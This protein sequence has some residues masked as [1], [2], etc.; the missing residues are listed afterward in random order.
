MYVII[1]ILKNC[2]I[3]LLLFLILM[4][5]AASILAFT[6]VSS[7]FSPAVSIVILA[8]SCMAMGILAGSVFGRRGLL[9]GTVSAFLLEVLVITAIM[10][11]F[12]IEISNYDFGIKHIFPILAGSIGGV[13][14]I[15]LKK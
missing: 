4:L 8:L 13:M 5:V 7:G 2:V 3:S 14:G 9:V 10:I 15:S 12:S 6:S 1:K 11:I